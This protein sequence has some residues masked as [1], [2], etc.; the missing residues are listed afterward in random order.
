MDTRE[1]HVTHAHAGAHGG[2]GAAAAHTGAQ[3]TLKTRP[4]L[5][6]LERTSEPGTA[7][8]LLYRGG[9]GHGAKRQPTDTQPQHGARTTQS[10]RVMNINL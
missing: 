4:S 5:E 2:G 1:A 6:L 7:G 9:A 8:L 3:L 10:P